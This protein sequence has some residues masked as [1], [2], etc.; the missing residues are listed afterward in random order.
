MTSSSNSF[1]E[2]TLPPVSATPPREPKTASRIKLTNMLAHTATN[3]TPIKHPDF[4]IP[5]QI[6][7]TSSNSQTNPKNNFE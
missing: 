5:A 7:R 4:F 6:D 2:M 1:G 3:R